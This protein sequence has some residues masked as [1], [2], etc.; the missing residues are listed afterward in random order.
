MSVR[1]ATVSHAQRAARDLSDEFL[2]CREQHNWAL[3]RV[4]R[5]RGGRERSWF[6]KRCKSEKHQFTDNHGY[7]DDATYN[8]ADGYLIVGLGRMSGGARA[9]I[10]AEM[11][12]RI[13]DFEL[14]PADL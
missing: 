12:D 8:Y 3:Y 10:R 4:K 14:D 5:V 9:A 1:H 7:V 11:L 6:C 2:A 13:E